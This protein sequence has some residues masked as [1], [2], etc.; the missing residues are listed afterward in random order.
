M[1]LSVIVPVYNA[2]DDVRLCLD[3]LERNLL[4]DARC[5]LLLVND[6]SSAETTALLRDFARAHSSVRLL[7]NP[8]NLGYLKTANR[9]LAEARGDVTVLLNSD[10]A[11]P[12]GFA[13]RVLACFQ[14]D[15]A[16]GVACPVSSNGAVSVPMRPGLSAA[17]VDVMD[18]YL[19]A[20]PPEYPTVILPCG[21]C[22]CV[23]RS[24]LDDV[25]L[26]DEQYHPGYYE[27]TD[28][29]MRSLHY[30]WKAVLI[31]NLYIYHKAHASFSQEKSNHLLQQNK[32]LFDKQ[33]S[34]EFAELKSAY[35][36][37][38]QKRRVYIRIYSLPERI[39]RKTVRFLAQV[40]PLRTLRRDIR[41]RYK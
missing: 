12:S 34:A 2:P 13:E 24:V 40:I 25:G 14:S 4:P 23:R 37:E 41:H 30:G 31:D 22:F 7:E 11:I 27:E 10:T 1:K 6:G 21:D 39:W 38:K 28:F 9:G 19:R 3:S 8:E 35:P 36:S 15:P 18:A 20:W 26:F 33:W 5:D 16:I 29:A 17:D 32:V